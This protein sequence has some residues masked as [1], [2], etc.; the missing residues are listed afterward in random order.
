[1]PS[2][3][4]YPR[5][6]ALALLG[7]LPL[8]WPVVQATQVQ[9]GATPPLRVAIIGAGAGGSSA[10]FWIHKAKERHGMDVQVDIF[11]KLNYVG[12]RSITVHP[13][14]DPSLP[15][16]ELG[17]SIFVPAN[18]NLF[19]AAQ[20]FGLDMIELFDEDDVT[21]W[22]GDQVLFTYTGSWWDNL[23]ILWRYGYRSP[24]KTQALTQQMTDRV[25]TMYTPSLAHWTSIQGLSKALGFANYT[26]QS[27][28][29]LFTS[30][31]VRPKFAEE[32]IEAATRVNYAQ[33]VTTIHGVGAGVC[34][35]AGGAAQIAGGNYKIF[36]EFIKRSGAKLHLNT[37]VSGLQKSLS[38]STS[39]HVWTLDGDSNIPSTP[40]DHVILAA[41][42]ASSGITIQDSSASFLP[43]VEYVR[44]HVTL[45]STTSSS[46]RPERFGLQPGTH[47][48]K[49]ILTTENRGDKGRPESSSVICDTGSLDPAVGAGCKQNLGSKPDFNSITYHQTFEHKGRKEHIW[50]VFSME[51]KSNEW[52][53]DV[54]GEGTVGWVYRKEWH[55]YPVL[56][57]VRSFPPVQADEGLW[58]V[59]SMEPFI[60]T[61]ETE[62]L[63]SRNI[64]D[65]LLKESFGHGICPSGISPD[66]S[67]NKVEDEKIYG[68][69]C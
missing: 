19:R 56:H 31:G 30:Q 36:E 37:T 2:L 26:T 24:S 16:E 45:V 13:Y 57:P 22:D 38:A 54:F 43:K 51:K 53:E 8:G 66:G 48:G 62:T 4:S 44:L 6:T 17:A 64:V 59:N 29:D 34:M 12:G 1:M 32:M 20:E 25:L 68:W 47:V 9:L 28:F 11:E 40:Y 7:T 65:N 18:K 23:K 3:T 35:V 27:G 60:S 63:S 52:L 67:G 69:D 46:A 33:D 5:L 15:S 42:F 55:S 58:Y 41:P 14:N 21:L 39:K 49:F 50:K 10:A 61:M